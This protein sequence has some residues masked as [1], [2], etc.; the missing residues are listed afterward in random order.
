MKSLR[1][2]WQWIV[3]GIVLLSGYPAKRLPAGGA[4]VV[5]SHGTPMVWN[6]NPIPYHYDRGKLGEHTNAEARDLT[7]RAFARWAVIPTSVLTFEA[8]GMLEE[9]ITEDNIAEIANTC[10]DL[11]EIIF[12][13]D[14]AIID[15]I[16]GRG[17]SFVVMGF[18]GPTCILTSSGRVFLAEG[19]AVLNGGF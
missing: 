9:N 3:V 11:N 6:V 19:W 4:L 18:A 1:W 17:S 14:G 15:E 12:D 2:K 8:A 16:L 5:D 10:N 13:E 7:D